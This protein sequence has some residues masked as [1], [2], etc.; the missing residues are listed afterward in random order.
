[1]FRAYVT[2]VWN[3]FLFD[4]YS[5]LSS[6]RTKVLYLYILPVLGCR[7]HWKNGIRNGTR[8]WLFQT[9]LKHQS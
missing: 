9:L 3:T 7:V 1:M 4:V 5:F 8:S 6:S 2:F